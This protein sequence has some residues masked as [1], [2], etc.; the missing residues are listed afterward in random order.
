MIGPDP[1]AGISGYGTS[2][3]DALR[4]LA[5]QLVKFGVW[6]E[7]TD[8]NHP[9]RGVNAAPLLLW[10]VE[11]PDSDSGLSRWSVLRW[12]MLPIFCLKLRFSLLKLRN[13][14]TEETVHGREVEEPLRRRIETKQRDSSRI[15]RHRHI[16][17]RL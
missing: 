1:V 14:L 12:V 13:G 15:Q 9:W 5:D 10:E 16:P 17:A 7:V 3:Y 8:P 6:I 4:D 2:V 11:L